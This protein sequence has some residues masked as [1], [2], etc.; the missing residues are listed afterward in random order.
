MAQPEVGILFGALPNLCGCP[1]SPARCL[2]PENA[3][4]RLAWGLHAVPSQDAEG[5][6][7]GLK[8]LSRRLVSI[9]LAY[10]DSEP[11]PG[12][13]IGPDDTSQV[14]KFLERKMPRHCF[15]YCRRIGL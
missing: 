14:W 9:V 4:V 2:R 13:L 7:K 11:A 8:V 10:V 5:H 6:G 15:L 1:G 3:S 12:H